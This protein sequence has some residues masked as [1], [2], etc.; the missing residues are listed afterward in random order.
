MEG[1]ARKS[2]DGDDTIVYIYIYS[3]MLIL[4]VF[5]TIWGC[6]IIYILLITM[7]TY[8]YILQ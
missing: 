4:L 1:Q 8:Y 7:N 2:G 5:Y 3:N 6:N